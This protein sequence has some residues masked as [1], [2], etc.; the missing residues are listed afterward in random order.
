MQKG[1]QHRDKLGI[2]NKT[3]TSFHVLNL[4]TG[5]LY[6]ISFGVF[7]SAVRNVRPNH[8]HL[9][10][11]T[12][13]YFFSSEESARPSSC[14]DCNPS[15]I[16]PR[17]LKYML[18][19]SVFYVLAKVSALLYDHQSTGTMQGFPVASSRNMARGCIQIGRTAEFKTY[20][21]C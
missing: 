9:H 7:T 21:L 18:K 12:S 5:D 15:Y 14:L 8:K 2:K 13:T 20:L 17:M 10:I 16:Y 11:E 1:L 3:W 4:I 19:P 6:G